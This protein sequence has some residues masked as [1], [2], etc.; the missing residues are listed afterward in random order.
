MLKEH[1]NEESCWL[2]IH[3]MVYDVTKLLKEHPGGK[4][5]LLGQVN[6]DASPAYDLV[7]HTPGA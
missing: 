6:Q 2:L 5:V 1:S 4:D 3:G 7:H